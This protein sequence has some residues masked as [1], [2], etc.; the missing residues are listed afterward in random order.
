MIREKYYNEDNI[1]ILKSL[2]SQNQEKK[3]QDKNKRPGITT[4]CNVI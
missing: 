4:T 3:F 2:Q 1:N